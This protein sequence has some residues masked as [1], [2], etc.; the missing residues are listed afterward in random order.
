MKNLKSI[1]I[2]LL[3][4]FNLSVIA[5]KTSVNLIANGAKIE[6]AGSNFAFTEGPAVARDGSVYFTDQPNDRI[7]VWNEEDGISLWLEGTGR[8]NGMYF[9]AENRLVTCADEKTQLAYF[10]EN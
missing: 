10:D 5:Q 6:Q 1:I 8:S 7:Y 9:D 4:A 2:L 3:F